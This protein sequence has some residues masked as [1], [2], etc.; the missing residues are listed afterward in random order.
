MVENLKI[1]IVPEEYGDEKKLFRQLSAKAGKRIN[2]WR[3]IRK[4]IDARQK[5]VWI[6]AEYEVATGETKKLDNTF[7]K[8]EFRPVKAD[9]PQVVVVG[10][11]P[12][13]LFAALRAIEKGWK[14]VVIERGKPVE[15]RLRD[16]VELQKNGV[17]NPESN[18]C[19]GEGG[20][21]AFSDGKLF[22]RS[23]KRGNVKEVLA[24]LHQHGAKEE[25]MY[26]AHPHIGSDK[27][28]GVIR[29]IRNTILENGGEIH[30]STPMKEL[31]VRG[32]KV[33]GVRTTDGREIEGPV[34]LATGHSARDIYEYLDSIGIRLEQKG[35]AMG[36]RLE[37]PQPLIDRIIYHNTG[38]RGAYL[39]P[40]EYK[41][42]TQAEG[43]GVYSF[44]MC[45]GGVIVPA[46]SAEGESVVNGMSASGRSGRWA[47]SGMVV[48]IRPEDFP[49][50]SSKGALGLMYLQRDLERKFYKESDSLNAAAQRM[51][52]FVKGRKS[53][54][55]PRT[56]YVPGIHSVELEKL[57]PDHIARRLKTGFRE[58]DRKNR[59]F[60]T[61][62]ATMI[63]L[64]SRTSTPV[65]IPRDPETLRHPEVEGLYPA[66]EGAGYAGGI[67]SAAMDG[68][69]AID[70]II[71]NQE[72]K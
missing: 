4:S 20:A 50:Y 32:G 56:S 37:H 33:E 42:V 57:L 65:R 58:F 14:P 15:E 48:E 55:L 61:N 21:G 47:N 43:R 38:G 72:I 30:Y 62:E 3:L 11:G 46:V 49:E 45:P 13:G 31:I 12:A 29:A 17:L 34:V 71:N 70:A 66:G 27:L 9:S 53:K 25:I 7:E 63:G 19:Y 51:E 24:L 64:E 59:G 6:D 36:V 23:K 52:D 35:F 8:T 18:F 28:P 5:Q 22:T 69:K 40:A 67:V 41:M 16:I 10:A 68:R 54:D 44:C 26:E 60:L 2:A 1:R 39:P